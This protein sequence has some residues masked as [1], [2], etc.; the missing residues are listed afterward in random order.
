MSLINGSTGRALEQ[1]ANHPILTLLARLALGVLAYLA[2]E[3]RGD[4]RSQ[5]AQLAELRA[6]VATLAEKVE[7][8]IAFGAAHDAEQN[9]RIGN[10]E[11]WRLAIGSR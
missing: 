1:A 3:L 2:I 8:R 10:L 11:A 7:Q 6:D 5:Q 4:V 9:R